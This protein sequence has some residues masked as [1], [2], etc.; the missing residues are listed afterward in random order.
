MPRFQWR[1]VRSAS[2]YRVPGER[3]SSRMQHPRSS[4][5]TVHPVFFASSLVPNPPWIESPASGSDPVVPVARE[6]LECCPCDFGYYCLVPRWNPTPNAI[7]SSPESS[8]ARAHLPPDP[9]HDFQTRWVAAP[10]HSRRRRDGSWGVEG[11]VRATC[12]V[13]AGGDA[14]FPRRDASRLKIGEKIGDVSLFPRSHDER[15]GRLVAAVRWSHWAVWIH[16]SEGKSQK[17]VWWRV[18]LDI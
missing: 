12:S 1:R 2:I 17:R 13:C 18:V 10:G 14:T 6:V 5:L 15:P 11:G 16:G 8:V 7:A 3:V 4:D 9:C